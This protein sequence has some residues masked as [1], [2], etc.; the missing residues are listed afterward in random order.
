[1]KC[2]EC[3]NN[4]PF[5]AKGCKLR[6]SNNDAKCNFVPLFDAVAAVEETK[7]QKAEGLVR[8][9]GE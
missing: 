2:S 5:P 6:V 7:K 9:K 8:L 3:N 4:I 1:M